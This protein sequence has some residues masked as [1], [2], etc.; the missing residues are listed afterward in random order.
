MIMD[1]KLVLIGGG[2]QC[3][4]VLDEFLRTNDYSEIGITDPENVS[5]TEIFVCARYVHNL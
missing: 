2:G 1:K 4:F 5:G 3:K